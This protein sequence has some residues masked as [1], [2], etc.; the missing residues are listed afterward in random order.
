MPARFRWRIEA[1][2][3]FVDRGG[4]GRHGSFGVPNGVVELGNE[5]I[6]ATVGDCKGDWIGTFRGDN[7]IMIGGSNG[8]VA[9]A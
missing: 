8:V 2:D 5:G 3:G 9:C 4:E 6:S 1:M 7:S